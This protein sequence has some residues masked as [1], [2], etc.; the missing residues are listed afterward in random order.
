MRKRSITD[1][2]LA[3]EALFDTLFP[4]SR[5]KVHSWHPPDSKPYFTRLLYLPKDG[6]RYH[7]D[8][9]VQVDRRLY[10]IEVKGDLSD[11]DV[12]YTKLIEL[13]REFSV[14]EMVSLFQR[15]G[16]RFD[17]MPQEVIPV[18]AARIPSDRFVTNHLDQAILI[19]DDSGI[20]PLTD[21]GAAFLNDVGLDS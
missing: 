20:Y 19:V 7:I 18:F 8:L 12:D 3:S 6:K 15:Q 14:T 9:I 1:E 11:S 5:C 2:A 16:E 10:L 13:I 21:A 17:V 4:L